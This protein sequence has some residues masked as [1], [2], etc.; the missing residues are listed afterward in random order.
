M[1]R[2][3][4]ARH[5]GGVRFEPVTWEILTGQ[6]ADHVAAG[7]SAS[8]GPWWRVA[9]DGAPPAPTGC[10]AEDLAEALRLRGRP[11]MAVDVDRFL[12]ADSLRFE[13]GKRDPD[14][15][16]DLWYD[17]GAL[18][19]EVFGPLDPG[20]DGHVLPDLRM[21]DADR[22]TRSPRVPL[23][24]GGVLL[25]HGPFLLGRWFPFDLTVHLALS[26]GAL[27]RQTPEEEQWKLPAF[28][29][30]AQEV[31]PEETADVCVR[32][33]KPRHPAWNGPPSGSG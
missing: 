11:A 27:K 31:A 19:R 32:V 24:E 15:Y 16:Y 29:R 28:D 25:L 26:A 23:P 17:T 12:R 21:P 7:L 14:A 30:Y 13:S 9:V 1:R 8:G 10:L 4:A 6:L 2:A 18:W 5:D 20:G 3:A 22:P 33:D